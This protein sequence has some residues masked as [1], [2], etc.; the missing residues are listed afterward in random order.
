MRQPSSS[1]SQRP[2]SWYQA[3]LS[4]RRAQLQPTVPPA[5]IWSYQPP[6]YTPISNPSTTIKR[7]NTSSTD[8]NHSSSLPQPTARPGVIPAQQQQ[9]PVPKT[10][11]S[12]PDTT[13][14]IAL[15][16]AYI[17]PSAV[18][19]RSRTGR[20]R[21]QGRA[22]AGGRS[23][24]WLGRML[25]TDALAFRLRTAGRSGRRR[26]VGRFR[27]RLGAA[28]RFV[29][30]VP[31][32]AGWG[33]RGGGL[34]RHVLGWCTGGALGGRGCCWIGAGRVVGVCRRSVGNRCGRSV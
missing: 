15:A 10:L 11:R 25:W 26:C 13:A 3:G 30:L 20:S 19:A 21:P 6:P 16:P 28:S 32:L 12:R 9:N 14:Y 4:V 29:G 7:I 1:I 31:W 27:A 22:R 18:R 33:W 5:I 24:G 17:E 8:Q 2:P 34:V 23:S